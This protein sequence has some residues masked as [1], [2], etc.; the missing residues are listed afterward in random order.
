MQLDAFVVAG[1]FLL[2]RLSLA[3]VFCGAVAWTA[4]DAVGALLSRADRVSDDAEGAA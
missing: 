1:L 2:C 3:L 4:S